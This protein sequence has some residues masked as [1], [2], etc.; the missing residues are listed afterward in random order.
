MLSY[1]GIKRADKCAGIDSLK[2]N[3]EK[4]MGTNSKR[5]SYRDIFMDP[6]LDLS[7]K[8]SV[9]TK[10]RRDLSVPKNN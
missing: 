1:Y 4:K 3:S 7:V 8:E 6:E 5:L 2:Q 10:A 9:I